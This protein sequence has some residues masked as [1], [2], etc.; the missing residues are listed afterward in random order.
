MA[1][2]DETVKN[3]NNKKAPGTD[4]ISNKIR[5]IACETSTIKTV[6]VPKMLQF[7]MFS[8]FLP[9]SSSRVSTNKGPL[10]DYRI[11]KEETG[12]CSLKKRNNQN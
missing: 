5:K 3:F 7:T 4:S 6:V 11:S 2:L 12:N 1:E 10:E 8:I 9:T